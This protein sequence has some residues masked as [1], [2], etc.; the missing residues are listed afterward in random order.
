MTCFI[1]VDK[2]KLFSC[3]KS[4]SFHSF[5][6]TLSV[7][8]LDLFLNRKLLDSLTLNAMTLGKATMVLK[9]QMIAKLIL[10]R[11]FELAFL[12]GQI[13]P[14]YRSKAIATSVKMLALMLKC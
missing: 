8:V 10:A 13:M 1:Y 12:S 3:L 4:L 6:T 5:K 2:H 7:S 14:L 9:T 11:N